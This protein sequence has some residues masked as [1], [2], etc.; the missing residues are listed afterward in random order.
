MSHSS[1]LF[2]RRVYNLL[3]YFFSSSTK[4]TKACGGMGRQKVLVAVNLEHPEPRQG[5][6]PKERPEP[7]SN[8]RTRKT[9]TGATPSQPKNAKTK[10]SQ[11]RRRRTNINTIILKKHL[12]ET[13]GEKGWEG[14]EE[15]SGVEPEMRLGRIQSRIYWIGCMPERLHMA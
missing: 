1:Y 14:G 6:H 5:T 7:T 2:I 10:T 9:S 11:N 15:V 8:G 3:S 12:H 13:L 4:R